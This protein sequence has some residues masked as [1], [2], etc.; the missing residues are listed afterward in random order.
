MDAYMSEHEW[1]D[2]LDAVSELG[3]VLAACHE[4]LRRRVV[5]ESLRDSLRRAASELHGAELR[6]DAEGLRFACSYGEAVATSVDAW[7][8]TGKAA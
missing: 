4:R 8:R 7:L 2:L 5:P 6:E 1:L 3:R